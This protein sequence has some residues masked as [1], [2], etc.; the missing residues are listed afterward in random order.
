MPIK[1]L[2][3][4]GASLPQIGTL[5]KGDKKTSATMP[6]KDLDYF[7]FVTEDAEA[8]SAFLAAYG[9]QPRSINVFLPF[10]T[11][12]ENFEAWMEEY[13]ASALKHRCDGE[14]C[15]LWLKG[16]QTYSTEPRPCP[17]GCKQ[18]GRLKVVIPELGRMAIV[19]VMMTSK[20]DIL[21]LH[22]SLMAI[23][24]ARMNGSL[25]GIPL[26]LR[27]VEKK[28]STPRDGK[29]MRV[30][31]W[32]LQIEAQPRW[33][34]LQL[35]AQERA[36]LPGVVQSIPQAAPL[37]I[38]PA[39]DPTDFEIDEDEAEIENG[40]IVEEIHEAEPV[41]AGPVSDP[42]ARAHQLRAKLIGIGVPA[43]AVDRKVAVMGRG[44]FEI[45]QIPVEDMA[46]VEQMLSQFAAMGE[47]A[48]AA[49]SGKAARK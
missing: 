17:G 4:R 18:T 21:N 37:Q 29:R 10:A 39:P 35:Q 22:A 24:E 44:V 34:A 31:K 26:V 47:G 43:E 11:V 7:R 14:T 9:A 28:I 13:T 16:D 40:E 45:D 42:R 46:K 32:L 25:R 12:D 48:I 15:V 1:G 38:G 20:H 41:E 23:D 3:D 19:T 8:E 30:T 2:T 49:M 27:R 36:A 6:G 33:V 5:R